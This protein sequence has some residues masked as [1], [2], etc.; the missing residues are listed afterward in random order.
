MESIFLEDEVSDISSDPRFTKL[1]VSVQIQ[2]LNLWNM[3]VEK[4]QTKFL[5]LVYSHKFNIAAV[6]NDLFAAQSS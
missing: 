3:G 2:A 4:D 5:D 6:A 1:P